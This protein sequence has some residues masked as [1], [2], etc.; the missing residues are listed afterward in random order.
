[1]WLQ[2]V[3]M[4]AEALLHKDDIVQCGNNCK[5]EGRSQENGARDPDPTNRLDLQQKYEEDRSNL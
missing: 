1:M 3:L 2:G 5:D 4:L